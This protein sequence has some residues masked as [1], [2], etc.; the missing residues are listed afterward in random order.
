MIQRLRRFV[1]G[2]APHHVIGFRGYG[3]PDRL[4][5]LA[6]ALADAGLL[7]AAEGHSRWRNLR[8]AV[9]RFNASPLPHAQ[10]AATMGDVT[11]TFQADDEGFVHHWLEL[12][13]PLTTTGWHGVEVVLASDPP[14]R[15]GIAHVLVPA[16]TARFAVISDIDDTVLQSR[17]S[18]P[19]KAARLMFFENSRTRLPFPGVAAFY[20]AL[21][22]GPTG[23]DGNPIFYISS[24]PWNVHDVLADFLDAQ[25]IPLGPLLLRDWDLSRSLVKHSGHKASRIRE[26]FDAYPAMSFILVGDTSQE[27][28]EIYAEAVREHPGRV[29]AIYI[30]DVAASEVR[31]Q[32]VATLAAVVEPEGISLVLAPETVTIAQHAASKGWIDAAHL[33][34]IGEEK[35]EDEGT[36]AGKEE[37]PQP[38]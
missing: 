12:P 32:A 26:L 22:D 1:R 27:D 15:A 19:L 31:R 34:D 9:K 33:P 7:A 11:A 16:S 29:L 2:D 28:P 38:E 14:E 25:G 8:E 17:V 13:A 21:V 5:V 6:R 20:R 24:S 35:R 23:S 36:V 18:T 37:P 30:R 4:Y 10:V 3:T